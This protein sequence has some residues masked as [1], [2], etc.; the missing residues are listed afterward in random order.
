MGTVVIHLY[1]MP[2]MLSI[3]KH[4]F[5]Y[6]TDIYQVLFFAPGSQA[7]SGQDQVLFMVLYLAL[8]VKSVSPV[9]FGSFIA[10]E[11]ISIKKNCMNINSKSY[12][13]WD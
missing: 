8:C 4:V 12:V 5:Y 11:F 7:S 6:I 10:L 9:P 1:I 13:S 3:K 2:G